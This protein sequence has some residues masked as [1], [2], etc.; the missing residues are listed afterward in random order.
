MRVY[1]FPIDENG[2]IAGPR[3]TLV[4]RG[5][6]EICDGLTVDS[7][8]NLYITCRNPA[9]PGILVVDEDGQE[10]AFL[11][12]GPVDQEPK[13]KHLVGIPSNVEFGV[14]DDRHTLY[15]TIDQ[16]FYYVRTQQAGALRAWEATNP[17]A[18][19][20]DTS[21]SDNKTSD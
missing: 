4:E 5:D 10:L 16:G 19:K 11:P 8:G 14:G 7:A 1:A 15:V 9:K 20:P 6:E 3:R 12:T 18:S 2:R 21:K 13:S 17:D